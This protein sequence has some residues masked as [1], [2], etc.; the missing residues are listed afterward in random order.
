MFSSNEGGLILDC[1]SLLLPL[2]VARVSVYLSACVCVPLQFSDPSTQ[3]FVSG[4]K[5]R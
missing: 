3:A 1:V 5:N 2:L 4:L